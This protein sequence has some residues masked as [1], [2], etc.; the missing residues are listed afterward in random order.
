MATV[1]QDVK[2]GENRMRVE[3]VASKCVVLHYMWTIKQLI[4]ELGTMKSP[5]K[6]I[7][8]YVNIISRNFTIAGLL[9]NINVSDEAVIKDGEKSKSSSNKAYIPNGY[10]TNVYICREKQVMRKRT[11]RPTAKESGD[12]KRKDPF[13]QNFK[14]TKNFQGSKPKYSF[15]HKIWIK[16]LRNKLCV[17]LKAYKTVEEERRWNSD[18]LK[19]ID[20]SEQ[21][22]TEELCSTS[23]EIRK[24]G[25]L[26]S[27]HV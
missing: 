3:A 26:K 7:D 17:S 12:R 25:M 20:I 8:L 14:G 27:R 2:K 19:S 24:K 6:L 11:L 16:P 22:S 10:Q 1:I 18:K 9:Q 5:H 13:E 4:R 23:N 15:A 21:N